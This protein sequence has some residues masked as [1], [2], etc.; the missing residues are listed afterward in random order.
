[1]GCL[2]PKVGPW[3]AAL[4]ADSGSG[5]LAACLRPTPLTSSAAAPCRIRE[6]SLVRHASQRSKSHAEQ[7][8]HLVSFA[9]SVSHPLRSRR[10]HVSKI[11]PTCAVHMEAH[12]RILSQS[13]DLVPRSGV[14]C[15][16]CTSDSAKS[17]SQQQHQGQQAITG[18]ELHHFPGRSRP[19]GFRGGGLASQRT[20]PSACLAG[21]WQHY[22]MDKTPSLS[23]PTICTPCRMHGRIQ[24]VSGGH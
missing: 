10:G 22:T 20:R 2:R 14:C 8:Q 9:I 16:L 15:T 7:L 23:A 19:E 4:G 21:R 5:V 17:S 3:Q 12:R 13:R 11:F 1:M 18:L 6:I 24:R